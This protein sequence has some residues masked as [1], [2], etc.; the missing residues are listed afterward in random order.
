VLPIFLAFCCAIRQEITF[1]TELNQGGDA[2]TFRNHWSNFTNASHFIRNS[3]SYCAV[4]YW[5]A[6]PSLDYIG[7]CGAYR[8]AETIACGN[9]AAINDRNS[10][11][12]VGGADTTAPAISLYAETSY[13]G[14]E[15][16]VTSVAGANIP[17]QVKSFVTSG[18]TSWTFF[19]GPNF[20]GTSSCIPATASNVYRNSTYT[21]QVRSVSRG[22][23][24]HALDN[25]QNYLT[26]EF[27]P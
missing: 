20:D 26:Q 13:V 19:S 21:G 17:F 10:I 8:N 25:V 14:T 9:N 5:C 4:G 1:Y 2:V 12:F 16:F 3:K 24:Q 27:E 7:G 6:Y 11:R 18:K 15:Y 23:G 22:C